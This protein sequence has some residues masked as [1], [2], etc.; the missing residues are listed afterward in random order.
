MR[1]VAASVG[2]LKMERNIQVKNNIEDTLRPA[3]VN[4]VLL[5]DR[6][7]ELKRACYKNGNFEFSQPNDDVMHLNRA[8]PVL[9]LAASVT[10][11]WEHGGLRVEGRTFGPDKAS[12]G[13]HYYVSREELYNT[14]PHRSVELFDK[15]HQDLIRK[16][17]KSLTDGELL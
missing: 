5:M 11:G 10:S 12:C 8:A 6:I 1:A 15:L 13:Y 7:A 9:H 2:T 17:A 14:T 3:T 4:E 16:L